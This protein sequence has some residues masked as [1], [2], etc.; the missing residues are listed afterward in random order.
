M[1]N[2][3]HHEVLI[4]VHHTLSSGNRPVP[5]SESLDQNQGSGTCRAIFDQCLTLASDI[6]LSKKRDPTKHFDR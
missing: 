6:H 2:P 4:L 1:A 3:L 5:T